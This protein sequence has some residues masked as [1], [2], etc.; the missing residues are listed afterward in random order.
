MRK[1]LQALRASGLSAMSLNGGALRWGDMVS[2]KFT[3]TC[4]GGELPRCQPAPVCVLQE[5]CGSSQFLFAQ[6]S[7]EWNE[8]DFH[9]F[10][11]SCFSAC[12]ELGLVRSLLQ[13]LKVSDFL[14]GFPVAEDLSDYTIL[15]QG[16]HLWVLKMRHSECAE[17]AS[18]SGSIVCI[19]LSLV[20][21]RAFWMFGLWCLRQSCMLIIL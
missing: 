7:N 5:S 2:P 16:A 1:M 18:G 19:I 11:P 9:R 13:T 3:C 14:V 8:G 4:K 10:Q 15:L 20:G 17:A 6:Y 12:S 21:H